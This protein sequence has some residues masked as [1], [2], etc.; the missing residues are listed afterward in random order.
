MPAKKQAMKKANS[1]ARKSLAKGKKMNEVKP[2]A[3]DA[4]MQFKD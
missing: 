1:T 2:L 3:V 4:Y